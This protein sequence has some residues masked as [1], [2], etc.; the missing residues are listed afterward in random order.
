MLTACNL[1]VFVSKGSGLLP[2]PN[3]RPGTAAEV[4]MRRSLRTVYG[5]HSTLDI[6]GFTWPKAP[7]PSSSP[8]AYLSLKADFCDFPPATEGEDPSDVVRRLPGS[9]P[10]TGAPPCLAMGVSS[11]S[12]H[13]PW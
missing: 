12:L 1:Q 4:C 2:P 7:L 8:S 11:I 3:Q 10:M 9:Y 5:M 13:C 6:R